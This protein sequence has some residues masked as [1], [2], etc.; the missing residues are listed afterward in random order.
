MKHHFNFSF[1]PNCKQNNGYR[2]LRGTMIDY[3]STSF[4]VK[5]QEIV[6]SMIVELT[7]WKR[8]K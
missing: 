5:Y 3:V 6:K 8:I 4:P 7:K 1:L 2:I